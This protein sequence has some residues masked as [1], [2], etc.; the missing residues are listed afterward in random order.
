MRETNEE[1]V[2]IPTCLFVVTVVVFCFVVFGF[3]TQLL[4]LGK[5]LQVC[6]LFVYR[7]RN[8]R[9]LETSLQT[10]RNEKGRGN[11]QLLADRQGTNTSSAHV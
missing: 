2:S 9:L 10:P 3:V 11:D 5:G 4:G 6:H 8:L 1:G 7:R